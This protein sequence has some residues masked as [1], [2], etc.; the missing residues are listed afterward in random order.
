MSTPPRSGVY[1][2]INPVA[3]G[4][5]ADLLSRTLREACRHAGKDCEVHLTTGDDDFAEL[6]ETAW[7]R[8]YRRF[9]AAGGDG[10]VAAV[11][12]PLLDRDGAELAILPVGTANKLA[13]EL[14]I[15]LEPEAACVLAATGERLRRIDAM[16]C[17][18]QLYFCHIS[19]GLYSRIAQKTSSL[20]KR[21]FRQAAYVWNAI[22]ELL[23]QRSWRFRL[24]LDG[25][26]HYPRAAFIMITNIAGVGAGE[27][28]W[29]PDIRPDD[30]RVDLCIVRARSLIDYLRF[31]WHVLLG[32]HRELS[33]LTYLSATRHI[34]V[35]S[36]RRQVPIQADGDALSHQPLDIEIMDRC[37]AFVVPAGP[38]II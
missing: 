36:R 6:I 38:K 24:E 7:C 19:L 13:R 3:G 20:A 30:G 5:D 35:G 26:S 4:S 27:L 37:V 29:G 8:G 1:A 31:A 17:D 9:V 2:V 18:G 16:R 11:A 33:N 14:G 10:T 23:G 32:R 12:T 22:P 21:R 28:S 15:P 34:R 25:Q